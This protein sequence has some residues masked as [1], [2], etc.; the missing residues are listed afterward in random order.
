MAVT[1]LAFTLFVVSLAVKLTAVNMAFNRFR[2]SSVAIVT[3][4]SNRRCHVN[5]K[6]RRYYVVRYIIINYQSLGGGEVDTTMPLLKT[7]DC[8]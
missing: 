6:Y 4:T 1:V 2:V 8:G 5:Q 7:G 3:A